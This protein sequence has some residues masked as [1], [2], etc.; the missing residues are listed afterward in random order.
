VSSTYG[1][2]RDINPQYS[3]TRTFVGLKRGG[4]EGERPSSITIVALGVFRAH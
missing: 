1:A 4:I 3:F 2:T